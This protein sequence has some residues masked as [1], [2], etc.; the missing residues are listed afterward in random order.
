MIFSMPHLRN[1]YVLQLLSKRLKFS[2]VIAI[3][4]A[5]QTGKSVLVRDIFAKNFK[6]SKYMTFDSQTTALFAQDNPETFLSS[7]SE[8]EPLILDEA[9]KAPAIFD[10]VKLFVDQDRRPG[11]YLLLGSTEFSRLTRI[12]ESLTGRM[13]RIRLYPF[14]VGEVHHLPMRGFQLGHLFS[15]TPRVSRAQFTKHLRLG[16]MPGLFGIRDDAE[17]ARQWED[18]IKL[19]CERDALQVEGVRIDPGLC[20]AILQQ[21][22]TL[23]EPSAGR[24]AKNLLRDLRKIKTHLDVLETLF[25][26]QKLSPYRGSA[27][28]PLYTLLDVALAHQ[29]GAS[30]HKCIRTLVRTELDS[31][32][33]Y[34]DMAF[35]TMTYFRAPAGG[36]IDFIIETPKELAAIKVLATESI[37]RRELE[38][39]KS[40]QTKAHDKIL[41]SYALGG[42]RFS[43][44]KE[45][46]EIFPWESVG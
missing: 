12:R 39:L 3:Q 44:K 7:Y 42:G 4:G 16:G 46:I 2:P 37:D 24:I 20:F 41:Y 26:V 25:V 10:A 19:T 30:L 27:G 22:A 1:R 17:R 15:D 11:R 45:K 32:I 34:Q 9:Q 18:W 6:T 38:I 40:F 14:M 36:M 23:D 21:V 8:F 33:A 28:K 13:G 35:T 5:R 29:L 43:L 31:L